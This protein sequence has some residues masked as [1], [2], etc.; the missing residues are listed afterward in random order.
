[1]L[2]PVIERAWSEGLDPT[3]R[4]PEDVRGELERILHVLRL[5]AV[6]SERVTT[7]LRERLTACVEALDA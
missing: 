4:T 1:M 5:D 7:W 6:P 2:H 3:P